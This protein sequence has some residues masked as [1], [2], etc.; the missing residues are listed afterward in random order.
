MKFAAVE[1]LSGGVKTTLLP[2]GPDSIDHEAERVPGGFAVFVTRLGAL[3]VLVG[4]AL[5]LFLGTPYDLP[6][7]VQ[8]LPL[9]LV[10]TY[11]IAIAAELTVG[12]LAMLKP[13]WAWL[14]LLT[15]LILFDVALITQIRDGEASCG[16]FGSAI[17]V[18]P[19]VMLVVD[20]V[21]ILLLLISRPW[22]SLGRD[23]IHALA[24]A[25]LLVVVVPLP[26]VLDRSSC[27]S[28]DG[29]LIGRGF[30]PIELETWEGTRLEDKEFARCAKLEDLPSDG[31]WIFYRNTCELCAELL[32]YVA[33]AEGGQRPVVLLHLPDMPDE[34][35]YVHDLPQGEHVHVVEL[36]DD[37]TWLVTPPAAFVLVGGC[38]VWVKEAM[39]IPDHEKSVAPE[40]PE[41]CR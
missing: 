20:S 2:E 24:L 6:Q 5:K 3:W 15:L 40:I 17:D 1:K 30:Y 33:V 29:P 10:L 31:L 21:L 8:Q 9:D 28:E 14:L 11:Q 36:P 7:I 4:A 12:V 19:I 39:R 38:V 25:M 34:K 27:P 35:S 32:E 22:A 13:R 37:G 26:W 18:P 41:G 16:C 23:G